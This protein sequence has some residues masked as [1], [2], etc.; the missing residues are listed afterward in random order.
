MSSLQ[1]FHRRTVSLSAPIFPA[2]GAGNDTVGYWLGD[3]STNK[4]IVAPKSTETQQQYRTSVGN[5][6]STSVTDGLANSNAQLSFGT[7]T[8]PAAYYCRTLATGG[9]NTWYL[10]A[11]N[12]MATMCSNSNKAPF[13]TL[14]M[15]ITSGSYYYWSSTE[16]GNYGK[17]CQMIAPQSF[18]MYNTAKT[19]IKNVRAARRTTI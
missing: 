5:S 7:S 11:V 12:E 1:K 19:L 4:L 17:Y 13:V 10:P 2:I 14:N 6:N 18:A 8:H 15:F 9:Y 16:F 3:V